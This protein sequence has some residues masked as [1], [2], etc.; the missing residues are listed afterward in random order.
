MNQTLTKPEEKQTEWTTI[1]VNFEE[2]KPCNHYF[3]W[4]DGECKCR[5]CH[6]GLLGVVDIVDGK[7]V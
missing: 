4:T 3:E 7:P 6:F 2:P 1:S 5:N